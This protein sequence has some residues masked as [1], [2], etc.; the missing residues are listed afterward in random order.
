MKS[1]VIDIAMKHG[2]YNDIFKIRYEM[3]TYDTESE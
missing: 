2:Y 3:K 1:A